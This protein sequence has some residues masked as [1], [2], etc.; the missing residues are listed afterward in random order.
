MPGVVG[1]SLYVTSDTE[2]RLLATE[3]IQRAIAAAYQ[4]AVERYFSSNP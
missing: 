1:E 2:S 4:R 3:E